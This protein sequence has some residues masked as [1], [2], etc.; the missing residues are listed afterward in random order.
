MLTVSY[1]SSPKQKKT[2]QKNCFSLCLF[3]WCVEIIISLKWH[4]SQLKHCIKGLVS[5]IRGVFK[6]KNPTKRNSNYP[7]HPF[8]RFVKTIHNSRLGRGIQKIVKVWRKYGFW[9]FLWKR[10]PIL[11]PFSFNSPSKYE[12]QKLRDNTSLKSA[13]NTIFL[14]LHFLI[15]M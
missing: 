4:V 13:N 5:L 14:I 15:L 2:F 7:K 8:T 10:S 12:P 11:M 6:S 1:Y 3:C 9:S